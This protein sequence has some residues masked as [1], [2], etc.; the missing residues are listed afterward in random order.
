M[1]EKAAEAACIGGPQGRQGC[2]HRW[3][4][5]RDARPH[6]LQQDRRRRVRPV[7]LREQCRQAEG[8]HRRRH[9]AVDR[10]HR[11]GRVSGF[12]PA[13]LL[14]EE[15]A[16]RRR[17]RP[18]G[19][20]RVLPRR[21]DDRPRWSARRIRPGCRLRTPSAKRSATPSPPARPCNWTTCARR[22]RWPRPHS[23]VRTA[24]RVCGDNPENVEMSRTARCL[25]IRRCDWRCRLLPRPRQRAPRQ[26]DGAAKPHSR[27]ALS[28]LVGLPAGDDRRRRSSSSRS[29]R[30]AQLSRTATIAEL[31]ADRAKP[32]SPARHCRSAWCSSL[33]AAC[34]LIWTIQPIRR[35][36]CRA[37]AD[38]RRQGR[39]AGDRHARIT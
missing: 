38:P 20:C 39:D 34:E 12:A 22:G 2:R 5:H 27:A 17:S 4:L 6:R 32:R 21:P 37:A 18:E 10:D 33:A 29:M 35:R 7:L 26:C 3:R 13:V 15:G 30:G 8:R 28:R 9:H 24:F 16:S 19:I 1:D 25:A 23:A 14:R 11:Q 36:R 31:P